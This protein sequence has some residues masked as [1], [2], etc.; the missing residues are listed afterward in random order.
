MLILA[1]QRGRTRVGG[2]EVEEQAAAVWTV[3]DGKL[4]R[5]EFHLDPETAR[6]PP[7]STSRLPIRLEREVAQLDELGQAADLDVS[8]AERPRVQ[9]RAAPLADLERSPQLCRSA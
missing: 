4:A 1:R 6:G 2:V 5:M 7:G 8:V 3:R 9:P